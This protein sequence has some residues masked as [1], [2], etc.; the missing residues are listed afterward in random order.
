MCGECRGAVGTGAS[1]S[2]F[3]SQLEIGLRTHAG[4]ETFETIHHRP[5]SSQRG[6]AC[7]CSARRTAVIVTATRFQKAARA[8]V[9]MIV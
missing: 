9:G 4:E 1:L 5:H 7:A 6:A 2:H 3:L 8:P